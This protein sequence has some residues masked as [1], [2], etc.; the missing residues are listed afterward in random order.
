MVQWIRVNR[1][2]IGLRAGQVFTILGKA[3]KVIWTVVKP[4]IGLMGALMN[5]H[6][7]LVAAGIALGVVLALLA[8]HYIAVSVAAVASAIASAAAWF[9]AAA[10][11]ALLL[12]MLAIIVLVFQD[13]W[14]AMHGGKSL[15]K[16]LWDAWKVFL[17]KWMQNTDGDPWWLILIK[18][19]LFTI[20]HLGEVWDF[21]VDAFKNAWKAIAAWW[22][23][24]V[25]KPIT[26]IINWA[27]DKI[28][29][30]GSKLKSMLPKSVQD[31]LGL[32]NPNT[33]KIIGDHR[34]LTKAEV[35]AANLAIQGG[36]T[37]APVGG[38]GGLLGAFQP[39]NFQ[40]GITINAAPGQ[41]AEEIANVTVQKMDG[42]WAS[43]LRKATT[44]GTEQ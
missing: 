26:A 10:P 18:N 44:G 16:D 25:T 23:E 34:T 24:H 38:G 9:L 15:L 17:D 39:A 7:L 4:L 33:N 37:T 14:V 32:N 19:F 27:V 6:H 11:I 22:D 13:V 21:V 42:W 43:Q 28:N 40:A 3:F 5:N 1:A 20:T 36:N 8:A 30:I 29:W 35:M 31:G 41:S 12:A 2:M